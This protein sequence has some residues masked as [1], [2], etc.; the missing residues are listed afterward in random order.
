MKGEYPYDHDTID[1]Y[2]TAGKI[3][4]YA[5]GYKD[6]NEFVVKYVGRGDVNARLHYHLNNKYYQPCFR[7][8]Y[9]AN[10]KEMIEKECEDYHSCINT[11]DNEIHP[12]LP[13]GEKCIICDH[14]GE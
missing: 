6:R 5:L 12:A 8:L 2:V 10:D 3:G 9:A 11:I 14:V 7:Y 13:K 1:Q 4:N